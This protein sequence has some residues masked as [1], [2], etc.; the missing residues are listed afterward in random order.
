[1]RALFFHLAKTNVLSF[2]D[3]IC[4]WPTTSRFKQ[5]LVAD[6]RVTR[7]KLR[8]H[9]KS[10]LTRRRSNRASVWVIFAFFPPSHVPIS[11]S[12]SLS[13][14][15]TVCVCIWAQFSQ[16]PC[17]SNGNKMLPF[18]TIAID[19]AAATCCLCTEN[20]SG[21]S[22]ITMWADVLLWLI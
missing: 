17:Y 18:V 7:D 10:C 16:K 22:G 14:L 15:D 13:V 9:L 20:R 5:Q 11:M 2:I 19:A 4:V 12:L 21:L 3:Q 1:M 6:R 8:S